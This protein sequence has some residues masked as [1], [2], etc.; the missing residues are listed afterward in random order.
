MAC[1]RW[2]MIFS[3]KVLGQTKFMEEKWLKET[4]HFRI[5]CQ[6]NVLL[7]ASCHE[8]INDGTIRQSLQ[9]AGF[10]EFLLL[11]AT[12]VEL[13]CIV[14]HTTH[15]IIHLFCAS[16]MKILQQAEHAAS[17]LTALLEA[18]LGVRV[19]LLALEERHILGPAPRGNVLRRRHQHRRRRDGLSRRVH[20]ARHPHLNLQNIRQN[21]FSSIEISP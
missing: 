11:F 19:L 10:L 8:I 4:M 16:L 7:D 12:Q 1:G 13:I 14:I 3:L 18:L 17:D 9:R 20:R 15:V 2:M 5:F 21:G 6:K